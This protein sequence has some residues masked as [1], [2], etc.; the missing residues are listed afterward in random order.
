MYVLMC[1]LGCNKR[2]NGAWL[3]RC[4]DAAEKG[5]NGHARC[6]KRATQLFVLIVW[7]GVV[8]VLLYNSPPQGR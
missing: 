1:S 4:S 6:M 5:C 3:C 8:R 2:C 7:C